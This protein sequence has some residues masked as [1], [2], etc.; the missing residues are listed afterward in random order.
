MFPLQCPVPKDDKDMHKWTVSLFNELE[1]HVKKRQIK[2]CAE[3]N[4]FSVVI[5]SVSSVKEF[6]GNAFRVCFSLFLM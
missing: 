6:F 5:G 1:L 4:N 2:P 3:F